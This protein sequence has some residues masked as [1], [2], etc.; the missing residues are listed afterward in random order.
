MV[1]YASHDIKHDCCCWYI[2]YVPVNRWSSNFNYRT[3]NRE[4]EKETN[5]DKE[6]ERERDHTN[7]HGEDLKESISP[8]SN[9][10]DQPVVNGAR[11]M[12]S[13][14]LFYI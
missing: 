9:L 11:I 7:S 1:Y 4:R 13:L 14:I 3:L 2:G 10:Q 5:T 6:W 8:R 12:N